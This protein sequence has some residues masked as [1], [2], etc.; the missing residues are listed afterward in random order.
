MSDPTFTT[1]DYLIADQIIHSLAENLA[2]D[3]RVRG[4][5]FNRAEAFEN[6]SKRQC[7]SVV[8]TLLIDEAERVVETPKP[9]TP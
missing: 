3:F 4:D 9:E 8:R 7:L 2:V 5:T 6:F 1:A